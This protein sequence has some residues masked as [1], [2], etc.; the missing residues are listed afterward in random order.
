MVVC[1]WELAGMG[2]KPWNMTNCWDVHLGFAC[3]NYYA[4]ERTGRLCVDRMGQDEQL[5]LYNGLLGLDWVGEGFRFSGYM[6]VF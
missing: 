6:A 5:G 4:T 3:V 2:Q 1:G